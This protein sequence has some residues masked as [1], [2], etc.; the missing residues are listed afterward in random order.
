MRRTHWKLG[1]GALA[2][3]L[4]MM[5]T[6][7]PAHAAYAGNSGAYSTSYVDGA[8]SL[9]DDFGDHFNELGNSLCYGCGESSNTDIV[10]LWQSILASEHLLDFHE[11][12]GYFGSR[13]R[14]AT[15]KWQQRH[16]LDDDGMVGNATWS[17]AD[18][19]LRWYGS[20]LR[21]RSGGHFGFV[22]FHRG[23]SSKS[24]DGGAYH[25]HK[26]MQ[27]DGV[28]VFET[29]TRVYHRSKTVDHY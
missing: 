29:G 20:T 18:D 25:L 7:S 1:L 4:S 10:M 16:G 23:D 6:V 26:V 8:G 19:R 13:T 27:G 28:Y 22:E 9:T 17:K 2:A 14:A 15:V 21:Y 5:L 11:I 24:S 3:G 12:D